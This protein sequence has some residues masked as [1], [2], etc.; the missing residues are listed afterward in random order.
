MAQ[1]DVREA[2]TVNQRPGATRTVGNDG[3]RVGLREMSPLHLPKAAEL[4]AA[5]IR[6]E[7]VRGELAPGDA[8]PPEAAL[9]EQF[10]ISRPTLRE[11]L[12]VLESE[13]LITVHR[14]A[15]GGA[16]VR[17]PDPSAAARPVGVLLQVKGVSLEDVLMTELILECGA[18]RL[19]ASEPNGSGVDTLRRSL[20]EEAQ[21]LDDLER[22]SACAIS[23]HALIIEVTCNESLILLASMLKEIIQQHT[24]LVAARQPRSSADR[25]PWR[26]KSHK[27][28]E[29][30][31]DLIEA[32]KA[33]EGEDLWRR[34]A[35]ASRRAMVK[36]MPV[37]DVLELFE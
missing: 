4:I 26:T 36:Q 27:V 20:V 22:F 15:R 29:E 34:H 12:R 19:L 13:Q 5:R 32:G 23:F 8:L 6:R 35:A 24:G 31:V 28:H 16:R 11:A 14:G 3:S 2:K 25:A 1:V 7:I 30:L 21:A 9:M 18:I 17:T 10:G 33:S 37:K